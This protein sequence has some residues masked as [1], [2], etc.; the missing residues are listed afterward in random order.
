MSSTICKSSPVLLETRDLFSISLYSFFLNK[1]KAQDKKI[2][3]MGK[4]LVDKDKILM[5][6]V[7]GEENYCY[8]KSSGG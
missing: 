6:K 7:T 4:V 3:L 8:W 2:I 1:D 5:D